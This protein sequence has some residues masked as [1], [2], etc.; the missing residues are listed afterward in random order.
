MDDVYKVIFQCY[1]ECKDKGFDMVGKAIYE[2]SLMFVN[3]DKF[4][5]EK[6]Q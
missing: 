6:N 3:I 4:L 5:K 1:T 2:Q